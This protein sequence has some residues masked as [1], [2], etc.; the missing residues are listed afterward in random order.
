MN[1]PVGADG[2]IKV[3]PPTTAPGDFI[4]LRALAD[5]IGGL[6]ACSAYDSC[7]GT[8]KPSHYAIDGGGTCS[9]EGA[10]RCHITA[11]GLIH[12]SGIF[13]VINRGDK[14]SWHSHSQQTHPTIGTTSDTGRV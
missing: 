3:E 12:P 2:R 11:T 5:L 10:R 7:G 13:Y 1:V 8:F 9:A 4:R 6:T 14:A